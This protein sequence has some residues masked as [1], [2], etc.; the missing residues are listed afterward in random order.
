MLL[1]S[2][3]HGLERHSRLSIFA[4]E[5]QQGAAGVHK[6]QTKLFVLTNP[7]QWNAFLKGLDATRAQLGEAIGEKNY[8]MHPFAL[9][10]SRPSPSSPPHIRTF[11][12]GK[13]L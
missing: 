11:L 4:H 1:F 13:L 3:S 7:L 6:L 9:A 12:A 10:I 2:Y 5:E 8:E